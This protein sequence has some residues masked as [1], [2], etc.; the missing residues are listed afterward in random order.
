MQPDDMIPPELAT[1]E[2]PFTLDALDKA[3]EISER[4][5]SASDEEAAQLA[6]LADAQP[7]A[8]CITDS[9]AAEWAMAHVAQIDANVAQ[10]DEQRSAYVDRITRWHSDAVRRLLQRRAF[11]A[12]HLERFAAEYRAADPKRHKTLRLPS[13]EVRSTDHKPVVEIRDAD[14]LVA[15]AKTKLPAEQAA[16]VVKTTETPMVGELRKV[17]RVGSAQI[18]WLV[19]LECGHAM[20]VPLV[21]P[22]TG[23]QRTSESLDAGVPCDECEQDPIDGWP[24]KAVVETAPHVVPAVVVGDEPMVP[25]TDD[26]VVAGADVKPG[27]V[28]YTVKPS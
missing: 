24:I 13:G 3:L 16:V 19:E 15:W 8:W 10:L 18:G 22:A 9:G 21:N 14:T 4:L 26:R 20:E 23:E 11:F 6:N 12:N 27:H 7:L 5:G 25:I 2:P 17:A 28:S 1:D